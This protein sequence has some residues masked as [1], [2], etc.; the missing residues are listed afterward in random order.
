MPPFSK[1]QI[2]APYTQQ[3]RQKVRLEMNLLTNNTVLSLCTATILGTVSSL[4]GAAPT[5]NGVQTPPLDELTQGSTITIT[6]SGFG[7]KAQ[8]APILYDMVDAAY[9]NGVLN[10][11]H[12]ELNDGDPILR[13]SADP[14]SIWGLASNGAQ[15]NSIVEIT[16]ARV[17]R[18]SSSTEH[19][20][21]KGFSG[22]VGWPVA[23][24]GQ[25][26]EE[27]P[28]D[29]SKLY[30]SWWYKPKYTPSRY[31]RIDPFNQE[32]EFI[33]GELLAING[34]S[35]EFIGIDDEGMINIAFR[36]DVRSAD[37]ESHVVRGIESNSTT[38]FPS[39]FKGSGDFGYLTPGSQKFIRVWEDPDGREGIRLSWTQMH[40]TIG[41]VIN[42]EDRPL[43]SNEWNHMELRIDTEA[44][45][46]QTLVNGYQVANF[47][48]SPTLDA[49]GK[50]SPTV[51]LL[52]LNG[53]NAKLQVNEFDDIYIDNTFQSVILANEKTFS[54]VTHYEL[55]L[56][57]EWQNTTVQ[58]KL[59]LGALDPKDNLYIF[60]SDSQGNF[61]D[62]GYP[63]CLSCSPP[64]PVEVQID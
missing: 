21:F 28:V 59:Q 39:V 37:L 56:P 12:S 48:F 42:W 57:V 1:L 10:N 53:K 22:Y 49:Q 27:T 34:F 30:V 43:R 17:P 54:D 20:Y 2:N 5:I 18:H 8:A 36:E 38:V 45:R 55:Q 19:Y 23:Y 50:W 46:V 33:P 25:S 16:S 60:V 29:E 41:G 6:G 63:L 3:N 52:G 24:G 4:A 64:S 11:K 47:N 62:E 44:G 13:T 61:P 14:D 7:S 31:W 51:A 32:G 15:G 26:G 9:E 58:A 40:H 35:A